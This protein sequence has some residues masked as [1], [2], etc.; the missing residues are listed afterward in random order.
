MFPYTSIN[1]FLQFTVDTHRFEIA[2][3]E[4]SSYFSPQGSAFKCIPRAGAIINGCS[5]FFLLC[6]IITRRAFY[7]QHLIF[8]FHVYY[9]FPL[10][11]LQHRREYY[12]PSWASSMRGASA[13]VHAVVSMICQD[14]KLVLSSE[15]SAPSTTDPGSM[16]LA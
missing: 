2:V 14:P 7:L 3:G 13:T 4:S 16:D 12:F 1:K 11:N 5:I 15:T 8:S 10:I 9:Y 6:F